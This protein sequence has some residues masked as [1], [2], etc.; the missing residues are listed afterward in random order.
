MFSGGDAQ[1]GEG[2]TSVG[3]GSP[4]PSAWTLKYIT[5]EQVLVHI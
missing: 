4:W 3:A 1:E 2:T 5:R